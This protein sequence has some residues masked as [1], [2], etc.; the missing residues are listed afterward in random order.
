MSWA[1]YPEE[2]DEE[3]PWNLGKMEIETTPSTK[4]IHEHTNS[5]VVANAAATAG[6]ATVATATKLAEATTAAA[7]IS[8][9]NSKGCATK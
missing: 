3:K 2:E 1:L 9:K 4:K 6:P 7:N 5:E 8:T